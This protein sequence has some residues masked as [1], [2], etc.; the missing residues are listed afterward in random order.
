MRIN[1]VG[2]SG[3]GKTTIGRRLAKILQH[4]FIEMDELFWGPNWYAPPDKE[5]FPNLERALQGEDW[6]L[7]GNYSRTTAIK[8]E[9]VQAVVWVDYR[10]PRTLIQAI[11]R[12]ISRIISQKELWPGTGNRETL[13]KLFSRE[14]IVLYTITSYSRK[15]TRIR[16]AMQ[17]PEYSHITFHH[18]HSPAEV[19][20]FLTQVKVE[21]AKLINSRQQDG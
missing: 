10:F 16:S 20:E 17:A 11:S 3:S 9:R 4:P 12:A 14:S 1:V 2:T 18:L 13:V 5:F 7:D 15:R 21:P 8:W 19:E 6:V